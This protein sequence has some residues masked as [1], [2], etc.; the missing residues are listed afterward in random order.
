MR[1]LLIL[2]VILSMI[3]LCS[4]FY[5]RV[6]YPWGER[7][8]PMGDFHRIVP[9]EAGST[10]S[11]ENT[12]GSIEIRGWEEEELEVYARKMVHWP[13][14]RRVYVYPWRDFAPEIVFD[15]FENFVK[16]KTE[17]ASQDEEQEIVDFSIDVPRS[18]NLKDILVGNGDVVISEV[19]GEADLEVTNGNILLDGFSGSLSASVV[20]GSITAALYDLREQ[21]EIIITSREGDIILSLQGDVQAR[22]EAV[23]P[24]GEISGDFEIENPTHKKEI[25]VQLGEG[26]AFISLT[27]LNG[28]IVINRIKTD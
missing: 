28:N 18:V 3:F 14:R 17:S 23:F 19:Y 2:M 8:V 24:E 7:G 10:L 11:V 22:L 21:D 12:A 15:Q 4:C 20:S 5:I 16:I 1:K 27:A 25:E 13:D 6:D 9:F 26:G